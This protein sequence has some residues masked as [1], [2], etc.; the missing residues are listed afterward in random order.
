MLV[1]C[2]MDV[3]EIFLAIEYCCSMPLSIQLLEVS[4]HMHLVLQNP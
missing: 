4:E 2:S 3:M 1:H